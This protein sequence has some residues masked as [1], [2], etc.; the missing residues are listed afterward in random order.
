[1]TVAYSRP[2]AVATVCIRLHVGLVAEILGL[3]AGYARSAAIAAIL[4]DMR[5][6]SVR[7]EQAR[8]ASSLRSK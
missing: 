1:M 3:A 5:A 6:A 7:I 4:G 8:F 2:V